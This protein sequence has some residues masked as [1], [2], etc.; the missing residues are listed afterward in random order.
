MKKPQHTQ[1]GT[2]GQPVST[3]R[4]PKD[5]LIARKA[6]IIGGH[7]ERIAVAAQALT[8]AGHELRTAETSSELA[9]SLREFRPDIII[10]DMQDFPDR[11]RHVASQLRA[12][13]STRQLPI[14]LVGLS[15]SEEIEKTDNHVT[16]PTRRYTLSLDAPSVL[17]AIL[18]ELQ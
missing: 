12:D 2:P 4:K 5:P 15:T 9:P 13:R 8:T 6:W 17:N 11:G 10:I 7:K 16:G 18:V 1:A 3:V 14:V